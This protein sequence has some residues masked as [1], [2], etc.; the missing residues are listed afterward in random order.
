M[1]ERANPEVRTESG[2]VRGRWEGGTAVFRGIPFAAPPVGADRF[3]APRP[4]ERWAG[5]REA[6]AFGPPPP[7]ESGFMGLAAPPGSEPPAEGDDWLTVNVWTPEPGSGTR[8]PVLVWIY[9]GAYK[10]GSADTP[11]YDGRRLAEDGGM[12]VVTFNHRVGM[13]GFAFFEGAPA[14]RGL[15]DQVAALEWVQANIDRFG[16]DPGR[17]TVAGQSAGAGSIASLLAMPRVTACGSG[18]GTGLLRRA[19]LQSTPGTFFTRELAED[20]GRELAAEAGRRPVAAELAEVDPRELPSAGVALGARMADRTSTAGNANALAERWGVLA[21]TLTPFSPVVDGEV[22]P[23][24]PWEALADG[25]ARGIDLMIG[26]NRDEN[27][28]FTVLA[29]QYGKVDGPT[30][31]GT[32]RA[33]GPGP[34]PEAAY[35]A[36][37]PS[38]GPDELFELVQ[39][40]WLFRIPTLRLADAQYAAGG[41]VHLYELTY[42]SPGGGGMFGAC[43]GLDGPLL[44]G[45]LDEQLGPLV[46]GSPAP[47]EAV[48]LSARMRR[49]WAGFAATGEPGWTAYD[50][51]ERTTGILDTEPRAVRYPEEASRALWEGEGWAVLG[52]PK[53]REN[54]G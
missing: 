16:G 50:P 15:L 11:G 31:A 29:G 53:G 45:T 34:D 37:Y 25:S 51:Q 35:R 41:R 13:E 44:F 21:L 33:F 24:P 40:D 48:D 42:D 7:Q 18:G 49:T 9:G 5:V 1:S 23:R 19:V 14:N 28:L 39:S 4:P 54:G 47:T 6:F 52:L 30:A 22:L 36:A 32:L 20:V 27:R 2:A 46:L 43:H 3:Q 38:A 26:H 17:V 10:L 12:V 8:R